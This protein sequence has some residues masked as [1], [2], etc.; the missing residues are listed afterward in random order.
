MNNEMVKWLLMVIRLLRQ[1]DMKNRKIHITVWA[2]DEANFWH[3]FDGSE[4]Y[5]E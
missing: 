1:R 2:G 3:I 4:V 5:K